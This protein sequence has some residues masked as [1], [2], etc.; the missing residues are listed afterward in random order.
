MITHLSEASDEAGAHASFV[1]NP[2]VE[3]DEGDLLLRVTGLVPPIEFHPF[4]V[5]AARRLGLHGWIKHDP[6]GALIRAVGEEAAL[7]LLVRSIWRES[8]P[9]TR[10]RSLDPEL[11]TPECPPVDD[12][13]VPLL[14]D[15]GDWHEPTPAGPS[16]MAHVA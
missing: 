8:P 1:V 7:A 12:H 3:H 13:F 14:E 11:V 15:T 9:S 10:I 4:V 16:P 6:S 5:R 2:A